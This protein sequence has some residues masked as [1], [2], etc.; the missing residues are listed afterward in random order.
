MIA[1]LCSNVILSL[2]GRTLVLFTLNLVSA[3][4]FKFSHHKNVFFPVNICCLMIGYSVKMQ[5][6]PSIKSDRG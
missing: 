5:G 3:F 2:C 1:Y 4:R 6:N